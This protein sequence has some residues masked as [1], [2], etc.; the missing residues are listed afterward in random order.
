MRMFRASSYDVY[1]C[2]G[3]AEKFHQVYD[4]SKFDGTR[5]I[6]T[7]VSMIDTN[8]GFMFLLEDDFGEIVGGIG[9]ME[10]QTQTS[11]RK[12]CTEGFWYVDERYRTWGHRLL[13]TAEKEAK[14]RG[15]KTMNMVLMEDSMPDRVASAY[16]A[17]GYKPYERVFTKEL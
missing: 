8:V 12:Q 1:R 15:C 6:D 10:H 11:S 7:W 14:D 17:R 9:C 3:G 4:K 16:A 13:M 5:F 2:L